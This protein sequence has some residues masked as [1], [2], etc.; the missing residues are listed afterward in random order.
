[1]GAGW[2]QQVAPARASGPFPTERAYLARRRPLRRSS[3]LCVL[4]ACGRFRPCSLDN[5]AV[6]GWKLHAPGRA[7]SGGFLRYG[8]NERV[9]SHCR[10]A[11]LFA[12]STEMTRGLRAGTCC[13]AGHCDDDN[14]G[15]PVLFKV[16]VVCPLL[17]FISQPALRVTACFV[18][19][20]SPR[21]GGWVESRVFAPS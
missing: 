4:V 7:S 12:C 8:L 1:M 19:W 14:D 3:L 10:G 6:T 20:S 5:D 18:M 11:V 9:L 13:A 21:R 17:R 16:A 2:P 15:H